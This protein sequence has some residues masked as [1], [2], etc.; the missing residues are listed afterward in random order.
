MKSALVLGV[1]QFFGKKLVQIL[2]DNGINVTI[3]TRGKTTDPFGEQVERLIIHTEDRASLEQAFNNRTGDVV[4]DQTCY[5]P[6]EALDVIEV[7]KGKISRY[8]FTSSQEVYEYGTMRNESEFDPLTFKPELKT[9]NE[10][11]GIPSY[12]EAKRS[13]EAILFRNPMFK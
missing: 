8:V 13:V 12:Q 7:L 3:A 6:I 11:S 5:S 10:Y 9:R 4:Y 1:T 2:L